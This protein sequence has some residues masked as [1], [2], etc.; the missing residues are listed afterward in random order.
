MKD[1]T[2]KKNEIYM[3]FFCYEVKRMNYFLSTA[4]K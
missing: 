2:T 1:G 3:N 4:R